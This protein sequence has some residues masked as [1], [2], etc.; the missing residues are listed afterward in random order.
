MKR[1]KASTED[2]LRIEGVGAR[3]FGIIPRF[4]MQDPDLSCWGK[5]LYAYLCSLAGNGNQAWPKRDTIIRYLNIGKN[6]YYSAQRELTSQGYIAVKQNRQGTNIYTL[7]SCP[8]KTKR[9]YKRC[10]KSTPNS[11][12]MNRVISF[13]LKAGGYGML[14]RLVMQD[15]RLWPKAKLVYAYLASYAGA[16]CVA[17]PSNQMVMEELRLNRRAWQR[18]VRE[19]STY[20]Y[21]KV[22][23]RRSGNGRY[24]ICDYCLLDT[25]VKAKPVKNKSVKNSQ[26]ATFENTENRAPEVTFEDAENLPEVT[27]REAQKRDTE[28]PDTFNR[29]VTVLTSNNLS[30]RKPSGDYDIADCAERRDRLITTLR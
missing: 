28:S 27:L 21:L 9:Q 12:D 7:I 22:I 4:A 19:L 20:G 6:T 26:K 14:P 25:P 13:G 10:V 17:F 15:D 18:S 8:E 24:D 11:L 16:G 30:I 2:L 1:Q 3:G 23:Q 5:L 29:L